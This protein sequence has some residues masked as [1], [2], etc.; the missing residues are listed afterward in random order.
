M[1]TGGCVA[2]QLERLSKLGKTPQSTDWLR[3]ARTC[4]GWLHDLV[5]V[6]ASAGAQQPW[7]GLN[8]ATLRCMHI[9]DG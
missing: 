3:C 4:R 2:A 9:L 8:C 6:T 7:P 5:T 1:A